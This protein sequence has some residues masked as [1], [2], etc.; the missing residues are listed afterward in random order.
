MIDNMGGEITL[1]DSNNLLKHVAAPTTV[2]WSGGETNGFS[3][4]SSADVVL[5]FRLASV[6]TA[7]NGKLPMNDDP[8]VQ[9]FETGLYRNI[10]I[11][12]QAR[13]TVFA[14]TTSPSGKREY[15]KATAIID[16]NGID[17]D[18][19]HWGRWGNSTIPGHF[20]YTFE[21][22]DQFIRG[23]YDERAIN[24]LGGK[25]NPDT[26]TAEIEVYVPL[27]ESAQ[28][29]EHFNFER[30]KDRFGTTTNTEDRY[31]YTDTT[32]QQRLNTGYYGEED[33]LYTE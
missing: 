8:F 12:P 11:V 20:L 21:A 33:T 31:D 5:P 30:N 9:A 32:S 26:N 14:D 22:F 3:L 16:L 28:Q 19:Y 4:N 23:E 2:I 17:L 7:L 15:V 27:G 29:A 13:G 18:K 10:K 1:T 25:Y 24:A 6:A